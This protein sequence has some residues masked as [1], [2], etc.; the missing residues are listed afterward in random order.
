MKSHRPLVIM[1][2][3]LQKREIHNNRYSTLNYNTNNNNK[4]KN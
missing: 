4:T 1:N 3:T 2:K